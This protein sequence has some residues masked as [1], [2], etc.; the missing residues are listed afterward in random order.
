MATVPAAFQYGLW[1]SSAQDRCRRLELL[2]LTRLRPRDYWDAAAAAAW[3]RGRGYFVVA[4]GLWIAAC[5]GGRL[6]V[7]TALVALASGALLWGLYF[8]LGFRAFARG[9]QANGL[10]LLLT[11]GLPAGTVALSRSVLSPLGDWLPPGMVYRAATGHLSAWALIGPLAIA[12]LTLVVSRRS[13][14][15]CDR[16]LREWYDQNHGSKALS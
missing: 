13:L 7:A 9:T 5:A 12:V 3:H 10:G 15:L 11:I 8:A 6:S 14:T 1:D 2:L 16:R 4:V